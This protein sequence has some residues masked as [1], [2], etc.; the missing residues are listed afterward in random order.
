MDTCKKKKKKTFKRLNLK[1]R[2]TE[3]NIVLHIN[4]FNWV[5]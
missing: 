2:A 1:L 3:Y 5:I 4:R